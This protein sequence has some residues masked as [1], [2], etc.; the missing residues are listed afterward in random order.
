MT[1]LLTICPVLGI[2]AMAMSGTHLLPI[3]I[4]IAY[5]DGAAAQFAVSMTLNFAVGCVLWLLT[6]RFK[7]ELILREGI[8]LVVIVWTGGA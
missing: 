2:I 3:A 8:L 6:R 4:S 1:W 5:D 7:R